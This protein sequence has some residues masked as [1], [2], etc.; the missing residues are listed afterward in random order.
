MVDKASQ[1]IECWELFCLKQPLKKWNTDHCLGEQWAHL[2]YC[3]FKIY[4]LAASVSC[5]NL[6]RQ[7]D[8]YVGLQPPTGQICSGF[9]LWPVFSLN[10]SWQWKKHLWKTAGE[11]FVR[12]KRNQ[13]KHQAEQWDN[14]P[15]QERIIKQSLIHFEIINIQVSFNTKCLSGCVLL[16]R[17]LRS[18][19]TTHYYTFQMW[20]TLGREMATRVIYSEHLSSFRPKWALKTLGSKPCQWQTKRQTDRILQI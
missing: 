17:H 6:G 18:S 9:P 20:A 15:A 1:A 3:L 13:R 16:L 5:G 12:S 8:F 2:L 10:L 4:N 19:L 11:T 7:S 14:Q